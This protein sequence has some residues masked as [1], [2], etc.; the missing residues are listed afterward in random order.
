M[1]LEAEG[2]VD[3]RPLALR[4]L[5]LG[6]GAAA[7]GADG[8]GLVGA[9]R[10]HDAL[11]QRPVEVPAQHLRLQRTAGGAAVALGERPMRRSAGPRDRQRR[12]GVRVGLAVP[13][14]AAAA[15][16]GVWWENRRRRSVPA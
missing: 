13:S 12:R 7:E 15:G 16:H 8:L 2:E 11:R 5:E 4:A 1:C 10:G 14:P 3:P 9:A 6:A